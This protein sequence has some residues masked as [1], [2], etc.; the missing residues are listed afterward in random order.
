[1]KALHILKERGMTPVLLMMPYHNNIWSCRNLRYCAALKS[2]PKKNLII[3]KH[4]NVEVI[5]SF[6]PRDL[7]FEEND[8]Y[9]SLHLNHQKLNEIF[10]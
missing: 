3:A 10:K 9:D 7:G 5:G 1:M 6:N 4:L 8:F 2:V